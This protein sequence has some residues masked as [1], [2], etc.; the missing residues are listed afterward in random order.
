MYRPIAWDEALIRALNGEDI[1]YI[2]EIEAADHPEWE[3]KRFV[4]GSLMN[5]LR[6]L[7]FVENTDDDTAMQTRVWDIQDSAITVPCTNAVKGYSDLDQEPAP[8]VIPVSAPEDISLKQQEPCCENAAEDEENTDKRQQEQKE[9]SEAVPE[10][11]ASK[12]QEEAKVPRKKIDDGRILSLLNKGWTAKQ[13][14][15]DMEINV[16]TAYEHIKKIRRTL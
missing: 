12:Q 9:E 7:I 6:N 1:N 16:S 5:I 11:A 8:K 13:I 4:A 10:D 3:E 2:G 14:A 15:D